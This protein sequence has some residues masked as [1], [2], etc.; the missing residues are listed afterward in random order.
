M[1]DVPAFGHDGRWKRLVQQIY[2]IYLAFAFQGAGNAG[3]LGGGSLASRG[4]FDTSALAW[5]PR[6][7][8]RC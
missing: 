8:R 5:V 4:L 2:L 3:H 1:V 6:M 7:G